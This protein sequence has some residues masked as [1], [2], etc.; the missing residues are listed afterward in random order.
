MPARPKLEPSPPDPI[1][2]ATSKPRPLSGARLFRG[3][4]SRLLPWLAR[5]SGC[6]SGS[7]ARQAPLLQ[8][9]QTAARSSDP[10]RSIGIGQEA[11][12]GIVWETVRAREHGELTV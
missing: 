2:L 11:A 7:P 6:C 12:D 9:A 3:S 4:R 5:V 1:A 10:Q 8:P